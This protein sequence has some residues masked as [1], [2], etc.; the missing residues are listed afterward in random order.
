MKSEAVTRWATTLLLAS[1]LAAPNVA[2]PH[3]F[4][5]DK[6]DKPKPAANQAVDSGS[7]GIFIKGQRVVTETFKI[8]QING[9]S[10]IKSQLKETSGDNP[11]SQKSDLAITSSGELL[12]YEW[13]QQA[14]GSLTEIGRAHV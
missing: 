2:A 12:H 14:G 9:E 7:F 10:I 13:S 3:A 11:T 1:S 5:S 4:G 6:K 8:E